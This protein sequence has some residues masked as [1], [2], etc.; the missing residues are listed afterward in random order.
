MRDIRRFVETNLCD[1]RTL[2]TR[3]AR[4]ARAELGKHI[5]KIILTLQGEG[6]YRSG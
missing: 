3:D 6:V 5:R 2:L 4:L 1:L